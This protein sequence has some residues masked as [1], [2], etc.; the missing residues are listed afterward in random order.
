MYELSKDQYDKLLQNNITSTYRKANDS[1]IKS[2]NKEAN[3]IAVNLGIE[4]R[5]ERMAKNQAFITLKDHKDN[6]INNPK[7]RLI[8]PAKSD[9]ERISK[10]ILE[11]INK[12][13]RET[14]KYHEWRN[15]SVVIDWFK[16]I[17]DKDNHTFTQFDI[18]NFY[19]LISEDLLQ[20]YY[21]MP[22]HK[23]T[24]PMITW[25]Y[26]MPENLFFSIK[27]YPG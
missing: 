3:D 4:D 8:N 23:Y 16:N 10:Q 20:I 18:E 17:P 5:V 11:K 25:K 13:I 21:L 1:I 26:Y 12:N 15:T 14:S 2:V 7:C 22:K 19:P 24:F 9:I 27:T 6:F